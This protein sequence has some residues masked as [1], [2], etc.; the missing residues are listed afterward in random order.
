MKNRESRPYSSFY[1]WV[2][3]TWERWN[4]Q[5][6]LTHLVHDR[7]ELQSPSCSLTLEHI[8]PCQKTTV[9]LLLLF[10]L[11]AGSSS[12]FY[13]LIRPPH[14]PSI[15]PWGPFGTPANVTHLHTQLSTYLKSEGK[16]R[17]QRLG[18]RKTLS[19]GEF[20]F[21]SRS[22]L[23]LWSSRLGLHPYITPYVYVALYTDLLTCVLLLLMTRQ[24]IPLSILINWVPGKIKRLLALPCTFR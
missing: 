7:S 17:W 12:P 2:N 10:L 4:D 5:A 1:K 8:R 11:S 24:H 22:S 14:F 13:S 18:V 3:W 21:L 16:H 23:L 19:W 15:N 20:H 6:N 9:L